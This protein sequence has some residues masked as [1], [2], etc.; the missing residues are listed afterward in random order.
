MAYVL[1]ALTGHA[2]IQAMLACE[3]LTMA[4][5]LVL[6]L[7]AG[8][9][10][11]PRARAMLLAI[12]AS[13]AAAFTKLA[14]VDV[15]ALDSTSLYHLAQIPGLVLLFAAVG[16]VLSAVDRQ[17]TRPSVLEVRREVVAGGVDALE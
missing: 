2:G 12:A 7:W 17:V 9:R 10:G 16:G 8:Y 1:I 6:W 14:G 15:L 13:G 3:S 5:I 11:H 4:S